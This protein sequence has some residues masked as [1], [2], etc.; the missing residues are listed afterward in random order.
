MWAVLEQPQRRAAVP[1]AHRDRIRIRHIMEYLFV[2][3]P[4]WLDHLGRLRKRP[5]QADLVQILETL[6]RWLGQLAEKQNL[7]SWLGF[8]AFFPILHEAA[9]QSGSST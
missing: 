7:Q 5:Q 2:G 9:F 4:L 1:S 3:D 6:I 8:A